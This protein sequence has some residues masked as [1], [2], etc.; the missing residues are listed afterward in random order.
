MEALR[1]GKGK[2]ADKRDS[3][4]I[5]EVPMQDEH[6]AVVEEEEEAQAIVKA[7][8]VAVAITITMI[9]IA[10]AVALH[11]RHHRC[12]PAVAVTLLPSSFC[13]FFAFL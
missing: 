5:Q 3:L 10:V 8:A 12:P 11:T 2:I 1:A 13:L 7:I 4:P 6:L 9:A